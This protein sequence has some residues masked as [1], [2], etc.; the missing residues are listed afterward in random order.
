MLVTP[1]V[2]R[3]ADRSQTG[4]STNQELDPKDWD[5]LVRKVLDIK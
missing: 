3:E 2:S 5:D 4:M 1:E